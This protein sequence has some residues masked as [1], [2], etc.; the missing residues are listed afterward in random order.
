MSVQRTYRILV[1]DDDPQVLKLYDR[2]LTEGGYEVTATHKSSEV[3]QI[4][5]KKAIELLVLDLD[6][7][8][9]DG[10]EVLK[11]LRA[12]WPGLRILVVSGYMQGALLKA[13]ERLGATASLNKTDAP[14][15]LLKTV[16]ALLRPQQGTLPPRD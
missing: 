15:L 10:F 16:D 6:M 5:R 11:F 9:P 8:E 7:P 4:L 2:I 12:D 3:L 13:S 14:E 1:V